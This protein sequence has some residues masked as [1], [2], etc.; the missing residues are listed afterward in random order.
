MKTLEVGAYNKLP[1]YA[2]IGEP[3][4]FYVWVN[5]DGHGTY[6]NWVKGVGAFNT[7]H[8]LSK[9]SKARFVSEVKAI[10]KLNG[11]M[12]DGNS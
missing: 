1:H 5:E 12:I 6:S 10:L 4:A 7:Y 8:K 3:C 9:L 2:V 11:G